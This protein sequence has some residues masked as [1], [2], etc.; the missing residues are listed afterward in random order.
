MSLR[1]RQHDDAT[2]DETWGSRLDSAELVWHRTNETS[3][4]EGFLESDVSWAECDA[5]VDDSGLVWVSHEP[6]DAS[7]GKPEMDLASWM[8]IVRSEGRCAKID[9][10]EGGPTLKTA[11]EIAERLGFPD[12]DLWFNATVEIL[13]NVGPH[14]ISEARP[15]ARYSCPLDTLA[16]Y[17][18]VMPEAALPILDVMRS[19][20]LNWLCIGAC[21]PGASVLVSSLRYRGWP[22]NI[23]DVENGED[24]ELAR[25]FDPDAITGDLG[26]I[27]RLE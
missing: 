1:A 4:I 14:R 19:W 5:R 12:E 25:S 3:E 10:K 17:L 16:P 27:P 26:S 11:L 13:G 22:M 7:I 18:L 8:Q 21:V 23:W 24:L 6:L 15:D 9:L 2:P 20:G